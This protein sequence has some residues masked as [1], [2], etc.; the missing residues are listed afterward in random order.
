MNAA[1]LAVSLVALSLAILSG[2]RVSAQESPQPPAPAA[3]PTEEPP[4]QQEADAEKLQAAAANPIASLVSIPF[5]YNANFNYGFYRGTQ[6][7]LNI[8]PVIPTDLGGGRTWVSRV[9]MPLVALPALAPGVGQ[10][11]GL[12]D[13]NPQFFYVPNQGNV[14]LG[15]G[16]T[17][18]LPT[19]TSQWVGQ[20]K[21][22]AG[23]D[24]VIVVTVP[25]RAVYGLLVNNVWSFAGNPAR[26][27]VNQALFQ[28]FYNWTLPRGFTVGL[29][30]TTTA[31]WNAPGSNKWT[32]PIGPTFSQLMKFGVGMGG[33]V[34][35]A[36][37]WNAVRP[38][39]GGTWT[40]RFVVTILQPA[41]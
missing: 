16:P 7:V 24:A 36:L 25:Q 11:V 39:Y 38:Q 4:A 5:Q 8:Q 10:Q 22:S 1:R 19:A 17:F 18:V 32:V 34:G 3:S 35:G 30:S 20:G 21:W 13:I 40:A 2:T 37:F 28:G 23:P 14:M 9:I 33:Q 12:G 26:A 31:N 29:T 15:Y 41:K 27:N 6:Q